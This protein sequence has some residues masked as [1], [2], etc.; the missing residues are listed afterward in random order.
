MDLEMQTE[1]RMDRR[2][3]PH[4]CH[5]YLSESLREDSDYSIPSSAEVQAH[6]CP[7]E[8]TFPV[9]AVVTS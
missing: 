3:M 2:F 8:H 4:L 7:K 6:Y 9:L 1:T 5:Q